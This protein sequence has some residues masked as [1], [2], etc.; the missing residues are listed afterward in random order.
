M[1]V[2]SCEAVCIASSRSSVVGT[3][4]DSFSSSGS[5]GCFG[6]F[7]GPSTTAIANT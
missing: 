7:V 3:T 1:V 5:F 6:S 2:P 4:P